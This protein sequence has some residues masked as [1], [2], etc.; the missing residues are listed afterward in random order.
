MPRILTITLECSDQEVAN[1]LDRFKERG[2]V[3]VADT[4]P[5]GP[6]PTGDT[7]ARGVIW[8]ARFHASTKNTNQDGSWKAR[9]GMSD[10]EKAD[11]EAYESAFTNPA[12]VASEPEPV[13]D[14]SAI[15]AFLQK[16]AAAAPVVPSAPTPPTAPAAPV[17]APTPAPV[18][19]DAL[20]AKFT[21]VQADPKVGTDKLMAN[22]ARIYE[23]A[24]CSADGSSLQTNETQRAVVMAELEKL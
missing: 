7:D 10:A 19:Y 13:A 3:E 11:A 4:S 24:G 17:V 9:R 16:S 6:K 18:T 23:A 14:D 2:A 5:E 1:L 22:L 21:A 12:P 20:I 8:D 15:P